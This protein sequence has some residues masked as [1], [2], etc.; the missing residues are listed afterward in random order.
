MTIYDKTGTQ[1]AVIDVLD[2]SFC[3]KSIQGS[4]VLTLYFSSFL[5]NGVRSFEFI[6]IPVGSYVLFNGETYTLERPEDLKKNHTRD[7]EFTLVLEGCQARLKKYK[8]RNTIDHR[9]KF[10]LTAKPEEFLQLIVDNLN[11]NF[12][13]PIST[14]DTGWTIGSYLSSTEKTVSFNHNF[15]DEALQM[16]ADAFETEWEI[17]SAKV[18]N[19]KR[20]EYNKFNP[21]NLSYGKGE[22]FL[23]GVGRT[24]YDN[25][26]AIEILYP[27]GGEKNIVASTYGSPALLLP[28][29][30]VVYYDGTNFYYPGD[31]I[32]EGTRKYIS[33]ADGFSICRNDKALSSFEEDSLDC[34][35]LYPSRVGTVSSVETID[36]SK[37]EYDIIDLSIPDGLDFNE[38]LIPGE[39][40]SI[41]FQSGQLAGREFD[42]NYAHDDRRF[43][44]IAVEHDGVMMPS[45][46]F[47]PATSDKY[48]VFG[49]SLPEAYV[50][51]NASHTGA[52][53][54]MFRESVKHLYEN[55]DPRFTFSGEL[56]GIFAKNNWDDLQ[57]DQKLVLGGYVNFSDTQFLPDGQLIR[58]VSIKTYV[59]SPYS[60]E[61][62]LSNVTTGGSAYYDL[63][64]LETE[65]VATDAKVKNA[66][67]YT[68]RRFKDTQETLGMLQGVMDQ[69]DEAIRPVTVST[70]ALLVGEESLQFR[71]VQGIE[72]DLVD[73]DMNFHFFG[74]YFYVRGGGTNWTMYLQHQT[75]GVKSISP[76]HSVA[77]FRHWTLPSFQSAYL[78]PEKAFYLYAKCSK[79]L[80][81][82]VMILSENAISM[83]GVEGHYHFLVGILNSEFEGNRSFV[84][85][86]GYT[87]ILPG[88]ITTD[89]L[90]SPDGTSYFDL[91]NKALKLGNKLEYNVDGDGKLKIIGGIVQN[92]GG[93]SAPIGVDRKE[94]SASNVYYVGD[95]TQYLGSSY[96]CDVQTT[97]GILPTNGNYFHIYA[98]KG[99]DGNSI[100]IQGHVATVDDL[101]DILQPADGDAYVVDADGHLYS[102]RNQ[103]WTDIGLFR[104]E[105]GL[106]GDNGVSVSLT[107]EHIVI[108]CDSAGT[109]KAGQFP[110][111]VVAKFYSGGALSDH[112]GL[113]FESS[114]VTYTPN[115]DGEGTLTL[116]ISAITAL[117]GYIKFNVSIIT[118]A[119][120]VW[121]T[122]YVSISKSLDGA[123]GP[124][125]PTAPL[126][127]NRGVWESGQ[128]YVGNLNRQDCVLY[129][130]DGVWYRA[131][132]EAGEFTD[133]VWTPSHWVSFGYSGESVATRLLLAEGANIA[134]FLF[135][136]GVMESQETVNG[137]PTLRLNGLTGV[138]EAL[139]GKIGNFTIEAGDIV[140]RD[141]STARK[142]RLTT[143]SIGTLASL[144]ATSKGVSTLYESG[145][146]KVVGLYNDQGE[147]LSDYQTIDGG[148]VS[149]PYNTTASVNFGDAQ[150]SYNYPERVTSEVITERVLFYKDGALAFTRST[151]D[152][153]AIAAGVYHVYYVV[154]IV[155][156]LTENTSVT[157]TYGCQDWGASPIRFTEATTE[158]CIGKDGFYSMFSGTSYLYYKSDYGVEIRWGNYILRVGKY[159]N[160]DGIWKS[161][162]GGGNFSPVV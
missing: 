96:Y 98:A 158:S 131:N 124:I 5:V 118:G 78:A 153:F 26:K 156:S 161:T 108:P 105:R 81:T 28:R 9:L 11:G 88:R 55:E 61:L 17:T 14:R 42:A 115:Y 150:A 58:I 34:S 16:I 25:S 139:I 37:N 66:L 102:Y 6:E 79:T 7:Y 49:I 51:D 128:T 154:E 87:E 63:K 117:S 57:L 104:G 120:G 39:N 148:L 121:L 142:V 10:T 106:T 53:W 146:S 101:D 89:R 32:P 119:N 80:E 132:P 84:S 127:P 162:N 100:A 138:L 133:N 112:E 122:K 69:F 54:D 12:A 40:L 47:K 62:T 160:M 83:E 144:M 4:N 59:N 73:E 155:V 3:S 145:F 68:K 143:G 109:P 21:I 50:C 41:I 157:C 99:A 136:N 86:F 52:S 71:F 116:T 129:G 19:L 45:T 65:E 1:I 27:Q 85:M 18:I 76:T 24:N 111:T 29:S 140:G 72:S 22:G 134:N 149:I 36:A 35:D 137:V 38:C 23:P 90:V 125:G 75:I 60:P 70:M 13:S 159:N 151:E 44:I 64:K 77:E 130:G 8:I 74:G 31:S 107:R 46:T 91:L 56:D 110:I 30:Q 43:Q 67:S 147:K 152:P 141:S 114:G 48:A 20:V 126:L 93:I 33:S 97:P 103:T 135:H 123:T 113:T 15:L 82:G 2:D 94:Y 92:A 95:I